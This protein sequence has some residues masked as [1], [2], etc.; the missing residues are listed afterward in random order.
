MA[1]SNKDKERCQS[2]LAALADEGR[3]VGEVCQIFS[4]LY[5]LVAGRKA[6][7]DYLHGKKI[8]ALSVKELIE[9]LPDLK[10]YSDYLT[11]AFDL[12]RREDVHQCPDTVRQ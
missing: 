2:F 5:Q 8:D 10:D 4:F 3:T 12:L 9:R 11:I 1:I 7:L 6:V